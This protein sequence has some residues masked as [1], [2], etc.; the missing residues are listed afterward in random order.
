MIKVTIGAVDGERSYIVIT[1][2]AKEALAF[3]QE[4]DHEGST[5]C[6]EEERDGQSIGEYDNEAAY[7]FLAD[8]PSNQ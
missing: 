6:A 1:P 3:L 7:R 4:Y 2:S 5:I 8:H